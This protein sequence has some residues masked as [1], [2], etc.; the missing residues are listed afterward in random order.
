MNSKQVKITG[1]SGFNLIELMIS[2]AI[3]TFLLAGV[4]TIFL[5]SSTS[6][7]QVQDQIAM[8]DDARFALDTISYDLRHAGV[9]GRRTMGDK[10]SFNNSLIAGV[11]G[12]CYPGWVSDVEND[13]AVRAFNGVANP[14]PAT[15]TQKY[16]RGDVLEMR[17]TLGTPVN[18]LLP[19]TLYLNADI[20][21]REFF[22]G[23]TSPNLSAEA[24]DFQVVAHAY[25]ISDYTDIVGDGIPSL[26][27]VALQA[28]SAGPEVVDEMLL[29]GVVDLQVQFGIDYDG[30]DENGDYILSGYANPGDAGL[31]E[32]QFLF[33]QVW[34]VVQSTEIQ[35]EFDTSVTFN[36][37]GVDVNYVNDGYR[38]VLLSTVVQMRNRSFD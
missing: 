3:G 35:R 16:S 8:L 12:E 15:C 4:F 32:N 37:A 38:K 25:Y 11:S 22:I 13:E 29:S 1:H 30:K 36:I 9:F 24:L 6:Q 18:N 27:R 10:N 21:Q 33:A 5:N 26:H 2:M 7:R 28:G 34:I 14:Y 19:N 20:N 31:A 17:Y 23:T